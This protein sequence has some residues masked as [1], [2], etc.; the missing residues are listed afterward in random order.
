MIQRFL[1]TT[2]RELQFAYQL[3]SRIMLMTLIILKIN[4]EYNGEYQEIDDHNSSGKVA[5]WLVVKGGRVEHSKK[6]GTMRMRM[7]LKCV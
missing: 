2:V 1:W 3:I 7:V 4:H 5:T 6:Y